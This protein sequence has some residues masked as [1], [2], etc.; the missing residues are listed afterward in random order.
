MINKEIPGTILP[1]QKYEI[2]T[3]LLV[4]MMILIGLNI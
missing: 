1:D 3:A 2:P 4:L